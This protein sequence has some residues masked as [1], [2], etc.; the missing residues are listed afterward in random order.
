M[1]ITNTGL[2]TLPKIRHEHI[3]LNN[4]SKMRVDLAT[5]TL[6]TTVAK[7]MRHFLTEEAEET[8][9][10]IEKIITDLIITDS[11]YNFDLVKYILTLPGVKSFFSE[12][13]S[14]DPLEKY[15]SRQRQRG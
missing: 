6:S 15:F 8:A 4:F 10:F 9:N 12:R 3:Y 5:Q 14:Q 11:I 1:T 2:T 7:A 13:I